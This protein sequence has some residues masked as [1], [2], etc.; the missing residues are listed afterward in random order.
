M[1]DKYP[2]YTDATVP[3]DVYK[4]D[5]DVTAIGIS[6]VLVCKSDMDEDLAYNIAKALYD[7]VA[8]LKEINKTAEQ[9]DE[10]KLNETS[11]PL[12]PGAQKYF[13]EK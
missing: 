2:Y 12:H 6:N 3:K 4:L 8:E 13:D 5:S 1:L 11:I 10:T 7:N 9:I